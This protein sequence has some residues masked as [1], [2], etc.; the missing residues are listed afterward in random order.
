VFIPKS[1]VKRIGVR[2]RESSV[3]LR[4]PG[5]AGNA[6]AAES[7]AETVSRFGGLWIDR[8]DWLDRLGEKHRRGEISDD[9][10]V[11]IFR[12]VRDGYVVLEGAVAPALV[13]RVNRDIDI[14][15]TAPPEGLSV[16][17]FEPDGQ[18]RIVPPDILLRAGRTKMLDLYAYSDV[19]REAIAAP[20]VVAFL[21]AIF[22]DRPKAFQGLTF[23]NGSQQAIHKD[24]AYVKI[25]SNPMH[26]AATWLAL[27]DIAPGTGEL[28]YY[29]GSH[30]A[31][32]YLFGGAS[33]WM[34]N[35]TGEHERFLRSLHDDAKTLGHVKGSFLAKKGDVL[36]WHADLAHGGSAISDP[37]RTRRS[38]VTHFTPASD[39]PFYRRTAIHAESERGSCIFV[40]QFADIAL[41]TDAISNGNASL[42]GYA[43]YN[44]AANAIRPRNRR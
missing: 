37:L 29:I 26:L 35:N 42:S 24:T 3:F 44:V 11:Q 6:I 8:Y 43:D 12:F 14:A 20:A 17:T 22:E 39:E 23:W 36:V 5:S 31:P 4:A 15:W 2:L 18:M 1:D 41:D 33:K 38:L 32:D 21:S 40:S 25:D 16:E 34:E 10:S 7:I 13:D 30:R 28:E 27:E 9:V 19:T